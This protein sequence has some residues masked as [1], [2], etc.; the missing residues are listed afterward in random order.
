MRLELALK[1]LGLVLAEVV[2]EH[3]RLEL[4]GLQMAAVLLGALDQRLQMLGLEQF[5]EL[6]LGQ[7]AV[8]VLSLRSFSR[9]TNL[10]S[11]GGFSG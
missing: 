1:E 7:S 9:A 2:L 5:D 11:V 6:V 8:S 3:E 10:R 4:G